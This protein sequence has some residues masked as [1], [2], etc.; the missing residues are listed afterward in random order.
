MT[1]GPWISEADERGEKAPEVVWGIDALGYL[2]IRRFAA[3]GAGGSILIQCSVCR[4]IN[5]GMEVH[6]VPLS[7]F[8][9]VVRCRGYNPPGRNP[10]SPMGSTPEM[11]D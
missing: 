2:G 9:Y 6:C 11:A 8:V 10:P 5:R 4:W 3:Y 7:P 1:P